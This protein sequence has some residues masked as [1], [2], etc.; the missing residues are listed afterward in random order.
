MENI[1]ACSSLTE[2]LGALFSATAHYL[3]SRGVCPYCVLRHL[4]CK[5]F[6]YYKTDATELTKL[7]NERITECFAETSLPA[8]THSPMPTCPLCHGVLPLV[9]TESFRTDMAATILNTGF[10]F[11][12]YQLLFTLPPMLLMRRFAMASDL[13]E[14]LA[15]VPDLDSA[16]VK[17]Y[18]D[19][20]R[21][22]SK[23]YTAGEGQFAFIDEK[24]TLK[25]ACGAHIGALV[26]R[27]FSP[28]AP[29]RVLIT[30]TSS[31][32]ASIPTFGSGKRKRRNRQTIAPDDPCTVVNN[33]T[34]FLKQTTKA[35]LDEIYPRTRLNEPPE[36]KGSFSIACSNRF[37]V[38]RYRKLG[39]DVSQSEWTPEMKGPTQRDIGPS[40]GGLIAGAV[41]EATGSEAT[42][43]HAAGREDIDVRML[44]NGRPFLVEMINAKTPFVD[45]SAIQDLINSKFGEAGE[46]AV[47]AEGMALSSPEVEKVVIDGEGNKK[48]HYTAVVYC[49][50]PLDNATVDRI[51]GLTADAGIKISQ[52]TPIRVLH[53][54]S[55]LDR[56]R[57]IHNLRLDPIVGTDKFFLLTLIT[58]AGTYVKEF[59]HGDFNR[60]MPHLGTVVDQVLG[61]EHKTRCSI[62]QLDVN[63][64]D[65]DLPVPPSADYDAER[66]PGPK[67]GRGW[68][69]AGLE[70]D[71]PLE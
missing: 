28:T 29:F 22:V 13:E 19:A 46:H 60:T 53:R 42:K 52:L 20:V 36:V 51:N 48:K 14:Y 43:F 15:A 31:E 30:V 68:P 35:E 33:V 5:V 16:L 40:V 44:G 27:P 6:N 67:E 71:I 62:L 49:S 10:Q 37:V 1:S 26:G 4:G 63:R 56:Q 21:T 57:E 45:Y 59:V 69:L 41:Q 39:R 7:F 54:R 9:A 8:V 2:P 12:E 25:W 11:R 64:V 66:Y 61:L 65:L 18:T 38:G 23:S 58:Q 70:A 34:A 17:E 24:E 55:L 3:L 32:R 50:T 47:E